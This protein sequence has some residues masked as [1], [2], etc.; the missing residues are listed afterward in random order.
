MKQ[1][2]P[3][4]L[5]IFLSNAL[6][7]Q[8]PGYLGKRM[9]I[10]YKLEGTPIGMN[11]INDMANQVRAN[12]EPEGVADFG[13]RH[14]IDFEYVLSKRTSFRFMYGFSKDGLFSYPRDG[15]NDPAFMQEQFP[16][17]SAY[18]DHADQMNDTKD[19]DYLTMTNRL[20]KVGFTF[21]RGNY[22]APH[23]R[24]SSL[25]FLSNTSRCNYVLND[26]SKTFTTVRSYGVMYERSN[27]RIIKDCV[28]LEYG[29]G[30]GY[31]FGAGLV[32]KSEQTDIAMFATSHQNNQLLLQ[33]TM[34]VRYLVPKLKK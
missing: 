20:L 27:R 4:L 7:A 10:G 29:L 14:N 31:L 5:L 15:N 21:S 34:G 30:I 18:Y 9:S 6:F 11:L 8:V 12:G 33:F 17:L 22:I 26:V 32:P 1:L 3:T 25:Y 16:K 19:Y 23:G 2:R 24:S 13:L 28:I